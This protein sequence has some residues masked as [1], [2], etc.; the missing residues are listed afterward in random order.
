[1]LEAGVNIRTIQIL[2]GHSSITSTSKYL[3]V[4]RKD[5]GSVKSPLDLLYVPD[6]KSFN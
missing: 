1:M 4:A 3:H 2:L 5:L 6:I